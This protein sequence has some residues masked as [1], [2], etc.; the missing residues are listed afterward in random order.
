V[1]GV[2]DRR[3][4]FLDIANKMDI[5]FDHEYIMMDACDATCNAA[6]KAFPYSTILMCYFNVMKNIKANC[7]KALDDDI[8]EELLADFRYIHMRISVIE[9]D[10]ALEKFKKKWNKKK[11]KKLYDYCT[12]WF[13]GKFSKWQIWHN[14]PGWANTNS[15]FESF[16]ATIKRDFSLRKQYSV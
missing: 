10:G 4:K 5:E 14:P 7:Q 8:Y 9:Y 13:S 2:V 12:S 6:K 11:Y 16:N 15:N 1:C 3:G